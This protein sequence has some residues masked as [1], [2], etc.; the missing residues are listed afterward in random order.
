M[1]SG[2]VALSVAPGYHTIAG[3][4]RDDSTSTGTG[5]DYAFNFPGNGTWEVRE[6][7]VYRTEG[8]FASSDVFTVA[9][10]GTTVKYRRNGSLVYTSKTP[11]SSPLVV[12]ASLLAVGASVQIVGSTGGATAPPP[13]PPA[14][15]PPPPTTGA[16]L[17][18]LQWNI[19]HGGFG[20]DNVY[21]TTASPRGS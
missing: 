12:D 6:S 4:G 19:H 8:P 1:T 18:V 20:T 15:E 7:G 3:L 17:R 9:I 5:I 10:E 13:P 2:S 11:V 16:T 21:H 14:T